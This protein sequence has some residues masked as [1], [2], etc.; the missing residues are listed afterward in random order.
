MQDV[1]CLMVYLSCK[2]GP[3]LGIVSRKIFCSAG[4]TIF[5]FS[6]KTSDYCLL[7]HLRTYLLTYSM[8]QSPP[9]EASWYC[10]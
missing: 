6:N 7:T 3:N 5:F 9:W 1:L 10:S 2:D 8:E 4:N